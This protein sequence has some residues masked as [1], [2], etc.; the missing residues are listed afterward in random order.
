MNHCT[1][2]DESLQEH[3]LWQPHESYWI[4]RSWVKG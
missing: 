1:Q 4:S 3:V 2:L